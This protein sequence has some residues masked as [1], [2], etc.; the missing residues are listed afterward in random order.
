MKGVD[1]WTCPKCGRIVRE[2]ISCPQCGFEIKYGSS[3]AKILGMLIALGVIALIIW[4]LFTF[5]K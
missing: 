4:K 1:E 3:W 2:T 5:F